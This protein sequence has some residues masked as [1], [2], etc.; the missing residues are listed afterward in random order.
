MKKL[1]VMLA[2]VGTISAF[3]AGDSKA[4]PA[5]PVSI[6]TDSD[7]VLVAGGCGRGWHRTARGRCVRNVG[8]GY[9]ACWWVRGPYGR[10]RLVCR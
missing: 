4:A 6:G 7:I 2:T 9:G 3:A 10:W 8:P 1:L 5:G